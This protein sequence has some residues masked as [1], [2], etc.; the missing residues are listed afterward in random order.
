[1]KFIVISNNVENYVSIFFLKIKLEIYYLKK[2][3]LLCL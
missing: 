3:F 2:I 1:M